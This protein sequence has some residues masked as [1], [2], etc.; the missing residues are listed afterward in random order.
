[1]MSP[2]PVLISTT[3][4]EIGDRDFDARPI[5]L[6]LGAAGVQAGADGV[7]LFFQALEFPRRSSRQERSVR[8]ARERAIQSD[9]R[10]YSAWRT[11]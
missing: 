11:F 4:P 9:C 6:R 8:S 1:M 10:V 5:A 7:G 2:T 3:T